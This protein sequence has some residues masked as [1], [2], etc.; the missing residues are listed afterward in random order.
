M[1][2]RVDT[3]SPSELE[4]SLAPV[5]AKALEV[6][7]GKR[8]SSADEMHA[9]VFGCLVAHCRAFYSVYLSFRAES[10]AP[11]AKL[12]FDELNHSKTPGGHRVTVYLD[13]RRVHGAG[14]DDD[15]AHGLLNSICFSPILSYGATAPLAALPEKASSQR[16]ALCWDEAPLGLARLGGTE[17]DREDTLLQEILIAGILL[18]RSTA[19]NLN[20]LLSEESGQVCAA[21]PIFAGLQQPPGHADY[22]RMGNY[23]DVQGGGGEFPVQPSSINSKAAS[24]FLRDRAGLPVDMVRLVEERS[25]ASAV[26][27]LTKLQGCSLWNHAA[28]LAEAD[29]T[30]EQ[31]GLVGKGCSGAP[32]RLD[33]NPPSAEQ[34][35]HSPLTIHYP[36][37][38]LKWCGKLSSIVNHGGRTCL[39]VPTHS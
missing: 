22:P 19:H 5:V 8:Y 33:G 23:L 24:Q 11:L 16:I 31:M 7:A 29:L 3:D 27:G 18:E 13:T 9:A 25:V 36:I 15:L 38:E 34:V 1:L 12:I 26:S 14:L 17:N 21:F 20:A 35:T 28:D 39:E 32:T 37:L 2:D 6:E 4:R 30:I 10:D